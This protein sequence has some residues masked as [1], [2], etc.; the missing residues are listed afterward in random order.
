MIDP[1]TAE[2]VAEAQ[3]R[4]TTTLPGDTESPV[5]IMDSSAP[6]KIDLNDGSGI[7]ES[8]LSEAP[9]TDRPA[10]SFDER[11]ERI[12]NGE[13]DPV[14]TNP[15]A[16]EQLATKTP[17]VVENYNPPATFPAPGPDD[18]PL[19]Q[20]HD[21]DRCVFAGSRLGDAAEVHLSG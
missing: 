7:S 4:S 10:M 12:V 13:G 19:G 9:A 14:T 5:V 18:G 3:R 2:T 16:Q 21:L 17:V 1:S 6:A 11:V 20:T 15:P 8:T